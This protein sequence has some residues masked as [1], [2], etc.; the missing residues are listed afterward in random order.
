MSAKINYFDKNNKEEKDPESIS[1]KKI[2]GR[3]ILQNKGQYIDSEFAHRYEEGKRDTIRI[4]LVKEKNGIIILEELKKI[5]DDR[6]VSKNGDAEILSQLTEYENFLSESFNNKALLQ[7]YK[8]LVNI[9]KN[10]GLP[11]SCKAN[12]L[13]NIERTPHLLIY[14]NY[15]KD[16]YKRTQKINNIEKYLKEKKITYRI[17]V[18]ED[19]DS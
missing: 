2:Q 14:N 12:E 4:D 7:Y 6:M 17:I 9:K 11:V 19:H 15:V 5:D 3:I 16:H 1:E 18:N 10:L 13:K 8:K